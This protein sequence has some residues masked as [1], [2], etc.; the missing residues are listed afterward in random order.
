MTEL[1]EE[2]KLNSQKI[3]EDVTSFADARAKRNLSGP[4][5]D[6]QP[7]RTTGG[8]TKPSTSPRLPTPTSGQAYTGSTQ[9]PASASTQF[10]AR[11]TSPKPTIGSTI[12]NIVSGGVRRALGP[13][14]AVLDS[15]PVANAELSNDLKFKKEMERREPQQRETQAAAT[16]A[17]AALRDAPDETPKDM[18]DGS[19]GSIGAPT[20]SNNSDKAA[21]NPS[22][23][24]TNPANVKPTEKPVAKPAGT[25]G[26]TM[27]GGTAQAAGFGLSGARSTTGS[28]A[29]TT[30]AP[31]TAA[32]KPAA[33]A[34]KPAAPKP[35]PDPNAT[36]KAM[37]QRMSD[38]G[39]DATSADFFAAD[40]QRTKELRSQRTNEETKMK[41]PM[42]EAF[43]KLH[44]KPSNNLF[45][46]A[47]K[48]DPVGK[49]DGDIDNDGDSDKSD[50]YLHNRRKAIGKAVKEETTGLERLKAK[51]GLGPK[52]SVDPSYKPEE[53]SKEDRAEMDKKVK[54]V[55]KEEVEQIDEI[56]VKKLT[57]IEGHFQ[58]KAAAANADSD[59]TLE[60]YLKTFKTTDMKKHSKSEAAAQ[61]ARHD[62]SRASNLVTRKLNKEDVEF[63]EAELAHFASILEMPVAPTPDDYSGPNNGPSKRDLSDE[64]IVET[65]KKDPSELKTRG[66]KAGVKVGAY[67]MKGMDDVAGDEAKAE[68]KNLV[69]QNPRTY[70][71]EGKNLVDLEHPSQSGVKRT[72][73]AKEY[74]SF[75]SSYLNSEKPEHKTKMHDDYVKRVFN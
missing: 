14:G 37:F 55:Q 61:K 48:L 45:V 53:K 49:E 47:K 22:V 10:P 65:K 20:A 30:P 39:D 57:G 25:S 54:E 28:V 42:I 43:M 23:S 34:P 31:K 4:L 52:S 13:V 56:S 44:A 75:R 3:N 6:N 32:P 38:K 11:S 26:A 71:K 8:P 17:I 60:K 50:K 73:P 68:P 46:E 58:A 40:K 70:S 29:S 21:E 36:S 51:V 62:S 67:K 66:R 74:N 69:A 19:L 12:K 35:A 33:P 2:V 27:P 63:S 18:P 24:A 41:S 9:L 64:T 72:V 15:T 1:L 16:R 7:R 59:K 5:N